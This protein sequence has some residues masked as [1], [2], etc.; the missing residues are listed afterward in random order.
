M[1]NLL[2]CLC[3]IFAGVQ[4]QNIYAIDNPINDFL[5]DE[6]LLWERIKNY[7]ND[8][9]RFEGAKK[10]LEF[11]NDLSK[12]DLGEIGL[13]D[14]VSREPIKDRL[15]Y[16]VEINSTFDRAVLL[17]KKSSYDDILSFVNGV[18]KT[19]TWNYSNNRISSV[20]NFWDLLRSVR[21]ISKISNI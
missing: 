9:N 3:F 5:S 13:F 18:P 15:K 1:H 19:V 14:M 2:Y 21:K 11:Y 8:D 17:L 16:F 4:S 6:R 7:D 20:R 10:V 12:L